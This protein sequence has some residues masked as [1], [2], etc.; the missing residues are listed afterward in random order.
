M[1]N[2]RAIPVLGITGG[3]FAITSALL[4]GSAIG[5]DPG[6][7]AE[8]V[9]RIREARP[10][11]AGVVRWGA[12]AD[13]LGYYLLPAALV[14]ILRDRLT[15]PSMFVRDLATVAGIVYATIGAIGAAMLAAAAPPLIESARPESRFLLGTVTRVVEGLWQ[16]LEA[17][18]FTIWAVG[19]ALALRPSRPVAAAV[20]GVLALGGI[21]V[22]LGRIFALDPVLIAGLAL[23]LGPFPFVL[24]TAGSWSR[25]AF[26]RGA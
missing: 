5:F 12:I 19:V 3:V 22:W 18:P 11:D 14:V 24:A 9:E 23:W 17:V 2:S 10:S 13:M 7:G 16:W 4:L 26:G 6:A 20:F 25:G 15:W 21:L 1:T 8:L